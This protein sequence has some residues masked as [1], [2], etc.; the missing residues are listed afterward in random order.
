MLESTTLSFDAVAQR[1]LR[2]KA[3]VIVL[4]DV[5]HAGLADRKL[6]ATNDDAV[7]RLI[8]RSGASLVVLS[9]S[10]GRQSSEENDDAAGGLFSSAF[11]KVLTI[12]RKRFDVDGNGAISIS[13][14]YRGLKLSV[15]RDS[16]GRQTPWLS[17]NLVVGDFD[18]F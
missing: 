10:K 16:Q 17:R 8:T 7:N 9:A 1:L 14:L 18:L 2:S 15:A 11:A 3:R 6:A 12:D 5:C 4:L 13:E